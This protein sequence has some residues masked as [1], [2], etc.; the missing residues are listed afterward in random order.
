MK[1]LLFIFL[2]ISLFTVSAFSSQIG[3][4]QV[5]DCALVVPRTAT[6]EVIKAL[7]SKGYRP[8]NTVNLNSHNTD[9]KLSGSYQSMASDELHQ[10]KE[11]AGI[12]YL[13]IKADIMPGASFSELSLGVVANKF[14]KLYK[15][16][17]TTLFPMREGAEHFSVKD[18]PNCIN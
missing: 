3:S 16:E 2:T 15:S 17:K 9:L 11:L 1:S 12:P 13:E 5:K 7:I 6:E 10:D 8:M 4:H 18:I 14:L